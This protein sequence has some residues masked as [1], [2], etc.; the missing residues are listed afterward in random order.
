MAT[1]RVFQRLKDA[2]RRRPLTEE[3]LAAH[4]EAKVA[5]EQMLQDRLSQESRGGQTYRSG[6]R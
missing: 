1:L 3:D 2:L 6:G 4:A 5:R